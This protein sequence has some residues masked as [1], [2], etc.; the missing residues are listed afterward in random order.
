MTRNYQD[1]KQVLGRGRFFDA[2]PVYYAL[3]IGGTL[4]ALAC[5]LWIFTWARGP[6]A[7]LLDTAFFSFVSVQLGFLM[8]DAGHHAIFRRSWKNELAGMIFGDLLN[9]LPFGWWAPHHGRHHAHPNHDE[10]DPDLPTLRIA[11]ALSEEEARQA[12]GWKRL[13]VKHQVIAFPFL[14][15]GQTLALK[16]FGV[17]HLVTHVSPRSLLE[18]AL[19]IVHHVAYFGFFVHY[20]GV[21]PG[22]GVAALHHIIVGTHLSTVLGTNHIGRPFA[23]RESEDPFLDQVEPSRNIRTHPLFE[24]FWGSLNHQ[25]EHHLFPSMS[26]NQ[27]RRALP[28]VRQFCRE[29]GVNYEEVSVVECYRQILKDLG[30]ISAAARGSRTPTS[31]PSNAPSA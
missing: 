6:I 12:R 15:P 2:Q 1:L 8:H 21:W 11:L 29:R 7:I 16:F 23:P 30:E 25:I 27:I 19:V 26:R 20:L 13:V 17:R 5:S 4:A 18:L 9:G 22:L 24:C 3:V 14:F 31:A 28:I 10:L